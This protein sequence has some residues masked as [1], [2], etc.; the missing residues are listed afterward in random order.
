MALNGEPDRRPVRITVPQTWH[1]A[2]AE[3]A[4]GALVAHE[5]RAADRRGPV[6]RRVG[7]G[8]RVLD[9][10]QRDDR[11]RHPGP[12][13]RAQRHRAAAQHARRRR[14]STRAP[15]AR[16]ASSPRRPRSSALVPW[17][18]ETGAVT[19][20][21]GRRPRTGPRYEARMLTTEALVHPLDGGARRHHRRSRCGTRRWSCSRAA[22]P[23]A[24]R[25]R[26]STRSPT[27]W[28]WSS[29]RS[30]EYWDE[31][32]CRAVGR[33][34]APGPFVKAS[35]TPVAWSRPAPDVGE[36]TAEVLGALDRAGAGRRRPP[37]AVPAAA[38]ALPLEGV[39]VADF[40]WIGVG[41]I[42][43]KALAD[44][45]ATVVHIESDKPG[46]PAAPRRSVQGRHPGHQPLPVLRLVQHVEAVAAAGPQAPRPATTSPAGCWPGATSPSTRSPPARWTALGL[47]YDVARA[48]NPDIIMA[49]TCLL[50]QYGPAAQLAGYGYHAAAV[51]GFYEITGW[52]DRP[53]AG[54][55]N[56]Y[57]DTDRAA[58][59]DDD[60]AG[61]ARPPPPH[62]RGPVH[63]PGPDGV[64]APLPRPRAAR[65][66]G[67]G[68]QRPPQRQP[69]PRPAPRTTPTRAPG[70][71]SGAPS[72]SRT[73]SS[74]AALR[75]GA[76]RAGVGH[77]PGAR[78]GGRAAGR[79]P[80]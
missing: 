21:V 67:V 60:A 68:H 71:T 4:L 7:A 8:G 20:G 3:S 57:T 64:G 70:S 14:S 78:H 41:P 80:S 32:R 58:L 40:S 33:C 72:P 79:T 16:S 6:R 42:T 55:F 73:T 31:V 62:R 11:P 65:R 44:H 66:A 1:H 56:A 13:H 26:R 27:C 52:D 37:I 46:R 25:W 2:A 5:R 17:M 77:G 69:R 23:G 29:W 34:A 54:P 30:R 35:A 74:G 19:P 38:D 28:R 43:A 36:H 15:T 18:V 48:L 49:T 53:P 39:K 9:R 59:P 51:S 61:R 47:G 50:G 45:G 63:R 10:P 12:E 75:D 76:R 24:S 22:S